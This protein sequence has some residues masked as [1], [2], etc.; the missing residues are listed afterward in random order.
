MAAEV[1]VTLK[2]N[3]TID[4][5]IVNIMKFVAALLMYETPFKNKRSINV[6]EEYI[7]QH[8]D[9]SMNSSKP[10]S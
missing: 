6:K 10:I 4:T 3:I 7:L 2:H 5:D 8:F 1:L 9:L